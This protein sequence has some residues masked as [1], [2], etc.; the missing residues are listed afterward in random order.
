[1]IS[2]SAKGENN[3]FRNLFGLAENQEVDLLDNGGKSCAV[4]VSAVLYL[5]K[6]IKDIHA[7]VES[8]EKDMLSFGW[9]E[10]P[11]LKVGAVIVWERQGGHLHVGFYAG[12][13]KAISNASNSSGVP[14][15]HDATYGGTRKIERIYWHK[16]L[17]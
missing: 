11:E 17:D 3:M 10:V 2:N 4:F 9:Q 8:T 13:D 16:S 6:L 7:T 14:E 1:M 15:V 12:N 5:Q